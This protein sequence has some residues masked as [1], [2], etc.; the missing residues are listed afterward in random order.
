MVALPHPTTAGMPSSRATIA[1]WESG[2]PHPGTRYP[3]RPCDL[4]SGR[5]TVTS[6]RRPACDELARRGCLLGVLACEPLPGRGAG[7]VPV[8]Q[9]RVGVAG[10]VA[11]R[12]ELV[13][14]PGR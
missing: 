12:G 8:R 5:L 6:D 9:Q 14:D 4:G 3:R 10:G 1:A 11:E 2:A 7:R 13:V